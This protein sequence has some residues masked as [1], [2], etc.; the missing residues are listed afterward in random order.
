MAAV[1]STRAKRQRKKKNE[2]FSQAPNDCGIYYYSRLFYDHIRWHFYCLCKT[3]RIYISYTERKIESKINILT[4][5][6]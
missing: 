1:Y 4:E 5:D 3:L 6:R 2:N